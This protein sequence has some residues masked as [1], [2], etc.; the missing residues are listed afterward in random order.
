M[1]KRKKKNEH[2][3]FRKLEE[4]QGSL[5]WS[6]L[7]S[8]NRP[9]LMY[10]RQNPALESASKEI[11]PDWPSLQLGEMSPLPVVGSTPWL[12]FPAVPQ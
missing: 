12:T 7:G 9:C 6:G 2:A 8:K 1:G 4:N 11:P 5:Q 3:D 10:H